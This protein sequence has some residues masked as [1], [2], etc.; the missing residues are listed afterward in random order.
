MSVKTYRDLELSPKYTP[1]KTE[2]YMCDEQRAYF[3]RLLI[4]QR[5]E[6]LKNSRKLDSEDININRSDVGDDCDI[7]N[8]EEEFSKKV[9][10]NE[11]NSNTI[12]RINKAIDMI[13]N[14]SYGYSIISGDEIGINRLMAQPLATLT[15]EE[16]DEMEKKHR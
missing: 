6:I 1:K 9:Q 14:G 15:L 2:K 8:L 3:Y 13:E 12:N 11:R 5:D 7:S 4:S 16:Q 10:F